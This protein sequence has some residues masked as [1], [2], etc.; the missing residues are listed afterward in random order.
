MK[1]IVFRTPGLSIAEKCFVRHL[2]TYV[3]IYD[4][5][6]GALKFRRRVQKQRKPLLNNT[7]FF[8]RNTVIVLM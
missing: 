4:M 6:K 2:F 1:E 8:A 7:V 3:S 5:R